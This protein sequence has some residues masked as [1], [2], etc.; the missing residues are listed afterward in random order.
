MRLIALT[1]LMAG[2]PASLFAQVTITGVVS[3]QSSGATLPAATVVVAGTANGTVADVDGRFELTMEAL[4]VTLNI[5]Y[6]GYEDLSVVV[7]RANRQL[8]IRLAPKGLEIGPVK[9]AGSRILEK[10][11]EAALTV[12]ALDAIAIR[13][14][15]TSDFYEG[16]GHLKGV[17]LTSAS[18]GFKIVNTRGFNSTSPVRTLQIIDAVDNQAPGLNFSLGN[19]LGCS[20]LDVQRVELIQGAS[21]AFYGPNA[22]NG[23]INMT[24]KSP[25]IHRGLTIG[26]KVGERSMLEG[27]MRYANVIKNRDG[28]TRF[29]YKLNLSYLQA[30][31]WE[32]NNLAAATQSR[33]ADDNPGSYDAV[34]RYGD[35]NQ[36]SGINNA[37]SLSGQVISPGLGIWHRTGYLERDLV[38][39]D[40]RNFKAAVA[41]HYMFTEDLALT[42]AA[43]F[44]SGTT[45]YQGDNRYSLKGVRFVQ[46]RLELSKKDNF[47]LRAYATHEHSGDSYDAV[48]TAILLQN[49]AKSDNDWSK[50]YRNYWNINIVPKV[51]SL[52]GFPPVAFPYDFDQADAVMAQFYDSLVAWHAQTRAFADGPG[53]PFS[54]DEPYFAPGTHEFDSA[55]ASITSKNSFLEGGSGFYDR[56]ALYHVHGEHLFALND[57]GITAGANGR[58]YA[59]DSRGTIFQEDPIYDTIP[60]TDS[61]RVDTAF[62]RIHNWEAGAY[63]GIEKKVLEDKLRLNLTARVDKNQNFPLLISP[64]LSGVYKFNENYLAR[65]SFS[66][67]IRNPTLT[68]QYLHYNVGRAILLGNIN[69]FDSLV[70]LPSLFDFFNSQNPD[71]LMYFNVPPVVPEKVQTI[72]VGFRGTL[73]DRVYV[74]ASY[75]YSFYQ[76]FIGYKIGADIK[77]DTTVN[78]IETSTIYRVSA[79]ADDKVSTQGFAIALNYY[80]GPFLTLTGNYSWNKLDKRGSDD[81]IIPA[82]NTPEHKF[83]VGVAGRDIEGKIGPVKY[84]NYGFSINYKWVEGFEF[85]GSPQ[86]TGFVPTYGFLDL[87]VNKHIPKLKTTVKLGASNVLNNERFT[88]Y[89]GP[90]VGR[91]AYISLLTDIGD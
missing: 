16:L 48:L 26:L 44:G 47:F 61:F 49:A 72:E 23:V 85:E 50:D 87:Q 18:I 17:D 14:S 53:S 88:V 68:D 29:A 15:P 79:N 77:I 2:L 24:T 55:F 5:T 51:Q 31:D 80:L 37:S 33:V 89:G 67:A 9:V 70:T 60:T 7:E 22:F 91:L 71:T 19:F 12:E 34:N 20:E 78:L 42:Y 73:F 25:F 11:K 30:N 36:T 35:E 62:T 40:S 64:A 46:N 45:V 10:Q 39:Y 13:E 65:L 76:D 57:I 54:G 86:F 56:S 84:R 69:G 74:D 4:P 1:L 8:K 63:I 21:S 38:D 3:D 52:P 27:A 43:N 83:N 66:S 41:G 32:A 75:Y 59:P 28:V 81:P 82:Y 58:L 90:F 6:V